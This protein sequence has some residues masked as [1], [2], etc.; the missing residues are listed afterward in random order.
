MVFNIAPRFPWLPALK[1][2]FV[3]PFY[4]LFRSPGQLDH[5]ST[6]KVSAS[7]FSRLTDVSRFRFD[8]AMSMLGLVDL[9]EMFRVMSGWLR[10][11]CASKVSHFD[12]LPPVVIDALNL[13][14]HR[15][16]LDP[17][18]SLS[19]FNESN[20]SIGPFWIISWWLHSSGEYL[21]SHFILSC[22]FLIDTLDLDVYRF[23]LHP[24]ASRTGSNDLNQTFRIICRWMCGTH[25]YPVSCFDFS[26]YADIY[27]LEFDS[28]A[29]TAPCNE[30]IWMF[31][32]TDGW[33][34]RHW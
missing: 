18:T 23:N 25:A 10:S 20:D 17:I 6:S 26:S 8:A 16:D 34:R 33:L 3:K 21:V 30:S 12:F 13:E 28:S 29:S 19:P 15:F 27:R 1:G 11:V 4:S 9:P 22:W 24:I 7:A 14:L 31:F 5:V 32:R 2:K